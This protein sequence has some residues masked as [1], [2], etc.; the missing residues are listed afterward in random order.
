MYP[1]GLDD[2]WDWHVQAGLGRRLG[3]LAGLLGGVGRLLGVGFDGGK[4]R[5]SRQH[6]TPV[7]VS[8]GRHCR[9][10]VA[11]AVYPP[12]NSLPKEGGLVVGSCRQVGGVE[13]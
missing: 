10:L 11:A 1:L 12:S 13:G 3:C 2:A 9:D 8:S 5:I 4:N 6:T 7:F